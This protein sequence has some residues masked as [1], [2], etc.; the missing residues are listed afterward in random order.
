VVAFVATALTL[1]VI[2][3]FLQP[4]ASWIPTL[5]VALAAAAVAAIYGI[6]RYRIPT[7]A[8]SMKRIMSITGSCLSANHDGCGEHLACPCSCHD[9]HIKRMMA[10][11]VTV[12]SFDP[13]SAPAQP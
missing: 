11:P 1:E 3:A 13:L 12:V 4:M 6:A 10:W 5:Q 7:A 8:R 2:A 9:D